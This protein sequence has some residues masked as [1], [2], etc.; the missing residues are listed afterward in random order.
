MSLVHRRNTNDRSFL[1]GKSAKNRGTA[2]TG[3]ARGV[4]RRRALGVVGALGM[5]GA[6]SA[7]GLS[8]ENVF[9]GE[10]DGI[11]VGSAAFAESQILAEIYSQAL[12]KNGFKS[13]TQLGIGAREAYLGALTS[14]AIDVIPEYS[15]NL[16]LYLDE[17]STAQTKQEILQA[18]GGVLD[19]NLKALDASQAENKDT[20]V[21]TQQTAQQ[22][23]L[24]TLDDMA[25]VCTE[26]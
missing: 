1:S 20:L 23:N 12:N 4:T 26:L 19:K 10:H 24:H 2:E 8:G 7:C 25:K 18:L 3:M 13:S 15:G 6:L 11:I 14:G 9:G 17:N 21:V 22:Y 5:L 16:L